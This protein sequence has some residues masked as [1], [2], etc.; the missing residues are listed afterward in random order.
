[1]D[2]PTQRTQRRGEVLGREG[3]I[4][5]YKLQRTNGEIDRRGRDRLQITNYK[6]QMEK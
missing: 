5:N 4:T 6:G 1:V 2:G 3:K